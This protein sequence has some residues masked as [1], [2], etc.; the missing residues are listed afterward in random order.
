MSVFNSQDL[1]L[2]AF[3]STFLLT[4]LSRQ[5]DCGLIEFLIVVFGHRQTQNFIF[6]IAETKRPELPC[7]KRH[8]ATD[9]HVIDN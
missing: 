3:F 6:V 2:S 8:H 1:R 7:L 4:L 5:L 9:S